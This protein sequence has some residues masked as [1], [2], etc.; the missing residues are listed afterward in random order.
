MDRRDLLKSL[1]AGSAALGFASAATA[2]SGAAP[3]AR[4]TGAALEQEGL[5]YWS[6]SS[7]VRVFPNSDPGSAEP[8]KFDH[9]SS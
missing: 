8:L 9:F 2:G 5:N 1:T 7:L 3:A 4:R 6:E